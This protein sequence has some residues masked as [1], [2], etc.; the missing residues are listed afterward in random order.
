MA[1]LLT[2]P[3]ILNSKWNSLFQGGC[4][5]PPPEIFWL[6]GSQ[7]MHSSAIL[8]HC[9]PIPLPPPL[10]KIFLSRFALISRMVQMSSKKPERLKSLKKAEP[11]TFGWR[12]EMPNRP[13]QWPT[14]CLEK[15]LDNLNYS[16]IAPFTTIE[17][18]QSLLFFLYWTHCCLWDLNKYLF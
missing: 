8:G 18:E 5:G 2:V 13:L 12:F 10:Q 17:N 14:F 4:G 9:T 15:C 6:L 7:M 1:P 11:C 16:S 3:Y